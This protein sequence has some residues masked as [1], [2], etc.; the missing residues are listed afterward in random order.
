[1]LHEY[2]MKIGTIDIEYSN[3]MIKCLCETIIPF[4][5]IHGMRYLSLSHL[6]KKGKRPMTKYHPNVISL[7]LFT[8]LYLIKKLVV[9]SSQPIQIKP[10]SI[11]LPKIHDVSF[12]QPPQNNSGPRY[13]AAIVSKQ[14]VL[15]K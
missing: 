1:M 5:N 6:F 10:A 4:K 13:G 14:V 3:D 9:N 11:K 15:K 12:T 2:S 8:P 7:D